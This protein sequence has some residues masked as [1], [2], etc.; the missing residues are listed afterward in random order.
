MIMLPGWENSELTRCEDH[1][2]S[3]DLDGKVMY[4]RVGR[5]PEELAIQMQ[6]QVQVGCVIPSQAI[7]P[8]RM[9]GDGLRNTLTEMRL[10]RSHQRAFGLVCT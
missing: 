1:L 6:S 2:V 7:H 10:C 3:L 5:R 9:E 4:H 8:H